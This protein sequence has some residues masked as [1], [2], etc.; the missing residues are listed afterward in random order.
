MSI[1]L[2]IMSRLKVHPTTAK[3]KFKYVWVIF[4]VVC[5]K[6][7]SVSG[8]RCHHLYINNQSLFIRFRLYIVH[9][10]VYVTIA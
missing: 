8:R 4:D 7:D 9:L 10:R 2:Y 1:S 5:L 6:S 3:P